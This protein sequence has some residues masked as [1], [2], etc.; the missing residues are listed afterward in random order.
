MWILGRL[1]DVFFLWYIY[2][3]IFFCNIGFNI[4]IFSRNCDVKLITCSFNFRRLFNFLADDG[5]EARNVLI[6]DVFLLLFFLSCLH[7]DNAG[8]LQM[9]LIIYIYI[10]IHAVNDYYADKTIEIY[11]QLRT[12]WKY[13]DFSASVYISM[14]CHAVNFRIG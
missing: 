13:T 8:F 4:A 3:Y 1:L 6:K 14:P 7:W 9:F 5:Y 2:I 10:C 12:N 11:Y